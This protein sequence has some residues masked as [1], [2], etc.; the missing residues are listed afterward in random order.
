MYPSEFKEGI[1]SGE[2]MCQPRKGTQGLR[3]TRHSAPLYSPALHSAPLHSTL[4][5]Y[6]PS[7]LS[8]RF[9][10]P[11]FCSPPL[12]LLFS[13]LQSYLCPLFYFLLLSNSQKAE[14]PASSVGLR[15]YSISSVHVVEDNDY[16]P[17]FCSHPR[18][19]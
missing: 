2:W 14:L 3:L 9:W 8:P 16:V 12:S 10:C 7:I 11:P 13:A 5:Y 19:L 15:I 18:T 4:L 17:E 6:D 1:E